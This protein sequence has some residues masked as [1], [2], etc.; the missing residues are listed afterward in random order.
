MPSRLGIGLIAAFWFATT[1]YVVYRDVV[2]RY[3]ANAPPT[4]LIDLVDEA[5]SVAAVRWAITRAGQPVGT[6]TTKTDYSPAD[7][8]FRFVNKYSS[9]RFDAGA[10]NGLPV[11][12]EVSDLITTTRVNRVGALREQTMEGELVVKLGPLELGDAT[13]NVSGVVVNGLLVG[14]CVVLYPASAPTPALDRELDPVPVP[15]GQVLNPMM[16]VHRLRGVQPGRR[17]VIR[18]VNPLNDAIVS[19]LREMSKGSP[20]IARAIP[21]QEVRELFAEVGNS[22]EVVTRPGLEPVTCWV[23][24]YR[25]DEVQARTWVGTADGRVVRQEAVVSG[26]AWRFDRQD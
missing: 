10:A 2:P 13:A 9:L 6:L 17:W 15:A 16:P 21:D 19:L 25:T 26:E 18:E 24:V 4:V 20:L 8:T 12:L 3:F 23:I 22:P 14:R 7:D 11:S 5:T 1:G